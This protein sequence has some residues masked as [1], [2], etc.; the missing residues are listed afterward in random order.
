MFNSREGILMKNLLIIDGNSIINRAFYGIR[1][2]SNKHGLFTNAIYGFLKIMLKNIDTLCPDYICVAFDLKAPT[3]RHK[4]Y[5]GYKAQRKGMPDELRMQM[6]VM[7]E[8]LSAMNIA[9]LEL[10][11]FEADDII[12]TVSRMCDEEG[13]KCHIL[14]G[15][16]DDL[17]LASDTTDV[18]LTITKGGVTTTEVYDAKRVFYEY[19]VTPSEFVDVKALMGDSSDNVPGVKG[20]GEKTAFSYIQK[21][22]SIEKLYENLDDEIIKPAARQKLEDG[23]DMAVL[24]K[25]LCTIDR[26][27]PLN[28]KVEDFLKKEYDLPRL[29]E[30]FINLEFNEFL[31]SIS[32]SGHNDE[33]KAE[34]EAVTPDALKSLLSDCGDKLFYRLYGKGKIDGF[35]FKKGDKVYLCLASNEEEVKEIAKAIKPIFENESIEKVS[36]D[37]KHS[38]TT[39]SKYG[40][41]F[42]RAYFDIGIGAYIINPSKSSYSASNIALDLLSISIP[43]EK[44][45]LKGGKISICD[46]DENE[47]SSFVAGEVCLIEELKAFEEEKI[48]KD[49]QEKL[50]YEIELP[51]V[52]VLADMEIY[53]F[54]ID[55]KALENFTASLLEKISSLEKKIFSLAGEEF[56]INSTKQLGVILF[57]KLGLK[58]IKKTKTGYSTDSAVLEKLL[59]KHEIIENII[60]YRRASKLKSTYGDGLLAVIN[61]ETE[62]I[63]SSF[64][65]TVTTTGRISST[66]PNL[67]N[68]PMR[69]EEGREIRKMFVPGNDDFI[70]T[71]ADYSQIELRILAHISDDEAMNE[72]FL[73]GEDIHASTASK[74]FGV[75]K[76][77]VTPLLRTRAKAVNFGIVYGMGDYSLSQDLHISVKEAKAYIESY[78]EKFKGVKNYLDKTVK[79]AKEKGYVTTMFGR[80]RFIPEIASSNYMTRSFG[81]RVAMNTPI[82]GSAAD[83]IKIAMVSVHK[84]LK[85]RNLKSRL[86]LQVHDELIIETAKNE[87]DEVKKLLTDCMKNAAELKCGLV[88]EAQTGN[89]WYDA[90]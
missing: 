29:T 17:Q 41:L 87:A 71:D 63:H 40:I 73:N 24:S 50:F 69:R 72:A 34:L 65:Q 25:K 48:K 56:N 67:Q 75:A 43:D 47:R 44:D 30:L 13:I 2:L 39:L 5:D 35:A 38:I 18:L 53:G 77:D 20:I 11:G 58:A 51:L 8:V 70:L 31:K 89:T 28:E 23:Y 15:D 80:K 27:V 1:L 22:K 81:E 66:E 84:E 61:P 88:A 46:V 49:G 45:V 86:I 85:K 7:K 33:P 42:D 59:G 3:F 64:N 74:V 60:E 62:R 55:K 83:I 54:K 16:R 32:S 21:F 57:E 19:G 9:T 68:I 4:M 79:D 36:Y 76:E 82:Q 90:H 78:F 52:C 12:G 10:E 37:I 6:P 14:T 26:L